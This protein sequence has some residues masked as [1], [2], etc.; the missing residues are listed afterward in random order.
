MSQ[1]CQDDLCKSNVFEDLDPLVV[2]SCYG[3]LDEALKCVSGM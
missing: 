2:Y 3:Y 1:K